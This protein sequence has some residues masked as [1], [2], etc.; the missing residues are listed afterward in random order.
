MSTGKIDIQRSVTEAWDSLKRAPVECIAGALIYGYASGMLML[1]CCIG[2]FAFFPLMGGFTIL[3][4]NVAKGR[5]AQFGD[6]LSGFNEYWKWMGLVS[7]IFLGYAATILPLIGTILV[8][9]ALSAV[10]GDAI[11]AVQILIVLFGLLTTFAAMLILSLRWFFVS[12]AAADGAGIGESFGISTRLASGHYGMLFVVNLLIFF[13]GGM[14]SSITGGM[15]TYFTS[16]MAMLI[17]AHIYLDLK[18]SNGSAPVGEQLSK[19]E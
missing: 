11:V 9:V 8:A 1:C 7:L 3:L 4:L 19:E 14:V 15:G 10:N 13:A 5:P 18:Q 12:Y 17:G 2:L 16:P 6:L